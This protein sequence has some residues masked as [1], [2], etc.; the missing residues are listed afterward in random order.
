MTMCL[1]IVFVPV[2][3]YLSSTVGQVSFFCLCA[4]LLVFIVVIV[5]VFVTVLY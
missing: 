2:E 5:F 4:C 3:Q 1:A